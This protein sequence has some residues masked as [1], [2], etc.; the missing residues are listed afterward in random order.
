M[1]VRYWRARTCGWKD[2]GLYAATTLQSSRSPKK[3]RMKNV[4]IDRI[5]VV[6]AL[7]LADKTAMGY[8]TLVVVLDKRINLATRKWFDKKWNV[9]PF[10]FLIYFH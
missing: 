6:V 10:S 2:Q 7:A 4:D 9:Q 8:S 5:C 1:I 3:R